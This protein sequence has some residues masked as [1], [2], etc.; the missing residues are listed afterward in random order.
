MKTFVAKEGLPY[1]GVLAL[2][3]L[4]LYFYSTALS[5]I[6]MIFCA[7]ILYFFRDP[8]RII[9][10]A[11]DYVLSPADGKVMEI[12][13]VEH[14][15][16]IGDDCAKVSIFLSPFD[17]HINR[18]PIEGRIKNITY[19]EGSKL[20]AFLKKATKNN[21][22]NIIEIEGKIRVVVTQI[23]GLLF[24]RI[25]LWKKEGDS[26]ALGGRVGMIKFGSG[27]ELTLPK[28]VKILIKV[29]DKVKAGE[30]RLGEIK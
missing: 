3:G 6:A 12:E 24:R 14:D 27:T 20:P 26:V 2:I 15:D 19:V 16:F 11:G 25:V 9:S 17:V 8:E 7:I 22:R 10:T 18:S 28:N 1:A 21:E 30:T 29:G 23:A 13:K 4:I 5:A